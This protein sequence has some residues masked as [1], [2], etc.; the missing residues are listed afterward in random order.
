MRTPVTMTTRLHG[1]L[2]EW[3]WRFPPNQVY[4]FPSLDGKTHA[5]AGSQW[6][7]DALK[8][9]DINADARLERLSLSSCRS[10]YISVQLENNQNLFKVMQSVHH[11]SPQ[12]TARYN[13]LVV[14]E[15]SKEAANVLDNVAARRAAAKAKYEEEMAEISAHVDKLNEMD[16]LE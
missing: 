8:A 2:K 3:M 12:T 10:R 15:S 11:V 7:R 13:R 1:E 4:L 16:G 9:L 5:K 6:F 14:A